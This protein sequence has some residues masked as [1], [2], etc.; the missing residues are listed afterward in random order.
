MQADNQD[1][2]VPQHSGITTVSDLAGKTIG[3]E[4]VKNNIGTLLISSIL[5]DNSV[6]PLMP[7]KFVPIPI[8]GT[9]GRLSRTHK[10]DA[11]WLP[12]PFVTED[13]ETTTRS[14]PCRR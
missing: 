12:Q 6:T 3:V 13:E 4:P 5:S 8:P 11:A 2:V 1:I 7:S 10:V 9:W 14:A